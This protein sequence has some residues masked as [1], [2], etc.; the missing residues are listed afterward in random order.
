MVRNKITSAIMS[1]QIKFASLNVRGMGQ[2]KR[3][4]SIFN[5]IKSRKIDI[6]FMQETHVD[7]DTVMGLWDHEWGSC[8]L[9]SI[10]TS[11]S[12][13]VAI[14][15]N[16]QLKCE[17]LYVEPDN[18]GRMLIAEC[19]INDCK[20]TLVNVYGYNT[21]NPG[22]FLNMINRIEQIEDVGHLCIGGDFN[23]IMD[24]S[25]DRHSS[26]RNYVQSAN[27]LKDYCERI[28]MSDIWRLHN[29]QARRYTWHRNKHMSA[30][31]IDMFLIHEDL[32]D[33]VI[34]ADIIPSIRSDHSLITLTVQLHEGRHGAGLW[35][36]N[37]QLLNENEYTDGIRECIFEAI[38]ANPC[39]DLA[40]IWT[41]IKIKCVNYSKRYGKQRA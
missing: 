35:K 31:R 1:E 2:T 26:D 3:H 39:N 22:F 30:S 17:I 14:L 18:N 41:D 40:E 24:P 29:P 15:F 33:M 20:F 4:K 37:D 19:K 27:V 5:F 32:S 11:Q 34:E 36:L 23:C 21:D 8:T 28:N 6:I 9:H 12:A 38:K 13:G 16:K 25:M 10:G 7:S